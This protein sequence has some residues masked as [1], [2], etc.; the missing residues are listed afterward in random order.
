M[1]LKTISK[2]L[3]IL[4]WLL[5]SCLTYPQSGF[6]F[7]PPSCSP[8]IKHPPIGAPHTCRLAGVRVP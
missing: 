3:K 1:T 6:H 7:L 4:F 8:A 5:R 2:I